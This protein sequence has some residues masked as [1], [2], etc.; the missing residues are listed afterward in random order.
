MTTTRPNILLITSDQQHWTT[1]GVQD[2][3]I[4]TPNLDKL[5]AK[6]CLFNRAYCPNPTCTPTRS[7]IITGLYPSQHGA[8]S[9]GTKL[10]EDVPTVGDYLTEAGYHTALVGKAH[11]QPL[12]ETPRYRSVESYP[13]LQNLQ[14]W[15]DW[16]QP[17]YGFRHIELARNHTDEGHCGQHYALWLEEKGCANWR[18]YFKPPTGTRTTKDRT[19]EIPEELHY[20]A[21]IAERSNALIDRYAESGEP[22]LLWSSFFDPH[23]PYLIPEPWASMYDPKDIEVP[24]VT[25][26]EHDKNPITFGMT[27]DRDADF[28][29]Y[30]QEEHGNGCHGM[31]CHL[32]DRD[33]LAKDIAIYYGMISSMDHY[34]GKILD[35]LEARGLADDTLVVFT[36]DHGHFYGHHGLIAKGPYHYEDVVRVPF[37]AR[38]PGKIA[39][40]SRS[41]AITSLVD[42]APT[43]LGAAGL[44]V[45][46]TMSG[47]DV[48]KAWAG[49]AE[50]PRQF[51][52]V[53]NHHNPTRVHLRTYIDARYKLTCYRND[54]H[55]ELFD[56][57]QD[58]GEID[59][60]WDDPDY[61]QLKAQLM[62]KAVQ[63]DMQSEPLYMPRIAGA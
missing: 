22:F 27:Q 8:W 44:D 49:E 62:L 51:A 63:R 11:F 59:N 57:E 32:R 26:G 39:S 13:I 41:E 31:H 28:S 34:I 15:R 52:I 33:E 60:K 42:L 7:S 14:F 40:G 5:A 4:K 9:L 23:P 43:F 45:P 6:G 12:K 30:H 2:P 55:G 19:W 56:L 35:H 36:S 25:P 48:S 58:P 50:N 21:W 10:P 20:N 37:L 3:N 29:W 18:D 53:E 46:F 38:W 61:A 1:L 54:E 17:F 47:L 16:D 24:Q